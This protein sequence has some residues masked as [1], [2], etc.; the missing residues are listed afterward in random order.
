MKR[1]YFGIGIENPK[2][3][4]NLGTLFRSAHIFGADFVFTIGGRYRRQASDTT[5]F[6][7]H[8]P[9]Y[10][11]ADIKDFAS[12]TPAGC[13]IV[14]VELDEASIPIKRFCHFERVVAG[15]FARSWATWR[16]S[17]AAGSA[18]TDWQK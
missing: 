14:G 3:E 8:L 11:Y 18:T 2:T 12:H 13:K 1:G 4:S 6:A 9:F 7:K 5:A 17:Y 16:R 10:Y 15:T